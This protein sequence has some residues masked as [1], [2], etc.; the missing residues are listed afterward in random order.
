MASLL[1][2]QLRSAPDEGD[3]SR[4]QQP[5]FYTPGFKTATLKTIQNDLSRIRCSYL[6]TGLISHSNGSNGMKNAYL[7][8]HL[9]FKNG[10]SCHLE[11]GNSSQ[12]KNN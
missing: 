2:C 6:V 12:F 3:H 8:K 1:K 11:R 9:T 10:G 7:E 4:F 5:P